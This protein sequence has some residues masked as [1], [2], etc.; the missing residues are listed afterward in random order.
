MIIHVLEEHA[1]SVGGMEGWALCVING[2]VEHVGAD[3]LAEY[4]AMGKEEACQL[5]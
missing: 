5:K 3:E 2:R 1:A 4:V